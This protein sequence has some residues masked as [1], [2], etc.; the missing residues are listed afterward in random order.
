MT[1]IRPDTETTNQAMRMLGT[2]DSDRAHT[3]R[4]GIF[5]PQVRA[6]TNGTR[7][8]PAP[9]TPTAAAAPCLV[10]TNS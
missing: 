6:C 4:L 3:D 5:I 1:Q 7:P 9:A 8:C 10:C 2:Y